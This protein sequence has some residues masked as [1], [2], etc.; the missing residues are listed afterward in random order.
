MT[1]STRVRN[2]L[3]SVGLDASYAGLIPIKIPQTRPFGTVSMKKRIHQ[4]PSAITNEATPKGDHG[5]KKPPRH[6]Q[7]WTT[8]EHE[9]FLRAL[10]IFPSGPWKDVASFVGTRTTRQVMTHAQKY[11]E[12]IKRRR[13]GLLS[14]RT[15]SIPHSENYRDLAV[16]TTPEAHEPRSPETTGTSPT[17]VDRHSTVAAEPQQNDWFD[18]VCMEDIDA[19]FRYF[20]ELNDPLL[21]PEVIDVDFSLDFKTNGGRGNCSAGTFD[22]VPSDS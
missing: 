16:I 12:K 4:E 3:F 13:R 14:P 7:P 20:Q 2:E 17:A 21:F 9:L 22:V 5:L 1:L 10:E 6:G 18:R 11:R 8:E 15:K 19:A